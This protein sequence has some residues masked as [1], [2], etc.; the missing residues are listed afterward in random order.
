M[1]AEA[2]LRQSQKMEA[3]GQLTG[4]IAHD[5]NNMLQGI[6]GAIELLER[7]IAQGRAAEIGRFAAAARDGVKRA[8]NLTHQLLA[9]SRRQALAPKRV[10]LPALIGGIAGLI[11]QTAGPAIT[12][13]LAL[14]PDC[15]AAQCDPN[16]LE[17]AILNLAINARDAM[18]PGGRLTIATG[19]AALGA[20]DV[21]G[22]EGA[23][24]GDYVRLSVS[25]TGAG[26]SPDVLEHA[27][28]PF[29]TTKPAGQ[30]TGL[31][32]SQVYGFARQSNGILVLESQVG[33][34][35]AVHLYL[36]RHVEAADI[37]APPAGDATLPVAGSQGGLVV[38][39]ED[40]IAIRNFG[41]EV[42]REMGYAV[43]D[44]GD[45]ASALKILRDCRQNARHVDLLVADVGLP[46]GLNG[47]QLADAAREIWPDLPTLLI[48]GYAGGALAKALPPGMSLLTKPFTWRQLAGCVEGM[49]QARPGGSAP[50]TPAKG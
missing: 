4:G 27:F 48:T 21:A 18:A 11:Q 47:R 49:S 23:A 35:T 22:W 43:L 1:A 30:G 39:V 20:A 6:A 38:L 13:D 33:Q 16:Q 34:G 36:P 40:E 41:A 3:V 24:P 12:F 45:G 25:D 37:L 10:E 44:A 28:E 9:F 14:Q 7:R 32:L 31:G 5:F 2:A 42:L 26:M 50:W 46:G 19:H 17:N 15:W 8:A 29:F